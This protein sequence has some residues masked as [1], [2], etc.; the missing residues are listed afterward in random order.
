MGPGP[1]RRERHLRRSAI[2]RGRLTPSTSTL[3]YVV[4]GPTHHATTPRRPTK[5]AVAQHAPRPG[6][7]DH[8]MGVHACHTRSWAFAWAAEGRSDKTMRE[9][10]AEDLL[11]V[12]HANGGGGRSDRLHALGHRGSSLP[13]VMMG[14]MVAASCARALRPRWRGSTFAPGC[15]C[16]PTTPCPKRVVASMPHRR[17]TRAA[18]RHTIEGCHPRDIMIS[19]SV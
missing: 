9:A 12:P 15:G 10:A 6:S 8:H 16:Q 1:T 2:Q 18:G 17:P 14:E 4:P 19:N 11:A 5:E 7:D 3:R 13:E